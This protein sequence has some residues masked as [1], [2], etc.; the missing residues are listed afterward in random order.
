MLMRHIE[1][2]AK[3][4]DIRFIRLNSE[5]A[6]KEAHGFYRHMGFDHEKQQVRFIKDLSR[7][8]GAL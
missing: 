5:A 7:E 4:K 3:E 6:R 8:N 1:R 2:W